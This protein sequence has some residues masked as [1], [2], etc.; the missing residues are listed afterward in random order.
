M[1]VCLIFMTL[2]AAQNPLAASA[3]TCPNPIPINCADE[4][5]GDTLG[6]NIPDNGCL[7]TTWGYESYYLLELTDPAEITATV[8]PNNEP[9][10]AWDAAIYILPGLGGDCQPQSCIAG[11]DDSGAGYVE[12]VTAILWPGS[13][14]IVVDGVI[15]W[16][17]GAAWELVFNDVKRVNS[18]ALDPNQEGTLYINTFQNAAFVGDNWG[19]S[20]QRIKGYRFKWGQRP[21]P[22]IHNPGMLYLSTYG[23]SVQHGPAVCT[24]RGQATPDH[25]CKNGPGRA[26][27]G[28]QGS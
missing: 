16:D 19:D 8:A 26:R 17:G 21:I 1:K 6:F 23:G 11:T 15:D 28:S 5:A 22:D 13:Y 3:Q 2:L 24:K 14:F 10:S 27:S 25:D 20:W 12:T 7:D 4:V 9:F 18:I